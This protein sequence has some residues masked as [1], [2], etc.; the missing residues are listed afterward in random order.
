MK[1]RWALTGVAL[2]AVLAF[3]GACS[4]DTDGATDSP[5]TTT[6]PAPAAS[7][8]GV[9]ALR[10]AVDKTNEESFR[11]TLSI[12]GIGEGRGVR[13]A[14]DGDTEFSMSISEPS[15]G[16][17]MTLA[18]L[19]AGTDLYVKFDLGPMTDSI[20]GLKGLG[21]KWVHVDET[22]LSGS[23]MFKGFSSSANEAAAENL[24]KGVGTAELISPT[25][26]KGTLD[27]TKSMPSSVSEADLAAAGALAKNVPFTATLDAQGRLSRMVISMP[28]LGQS[29][30]GE[31]V[32]TYSDFGTVAKVEKP[33]A[34]DVV[35]APAE[36]YQM[37]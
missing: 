16:L 6:P 11:Y 33:A 18:S 32:T 2:A 4:K 5:P 22:K 14:A 8:S 17:K 7:G 23:G 9:E 20:P 36:L 31:I 25:E 3:T 30:A 15:S 21:D 12:L 35:E 37:L 1:P 27:I 28:A 10:A 29:K 24:V 19:K 26:I 34:S 13:D